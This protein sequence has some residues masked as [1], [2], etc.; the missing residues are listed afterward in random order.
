MK[1]LL[2]SFFSFLFIN[3]I[4]SAQISVLPRL[5]KDSVKIIQPTKLRSSPMLVAFFKTDDTYIKI[6]YGSPLKKDRK[7]FGDLVPYGKLWRTG[8]NEA[9]EIT[10]TKDI[11]ISGKSLKAGTYTIFTIPN[12]NSWT[13]LINND[14]GQWGDYQYKPEN[15]ILSFEIPVEKTP[16][17]IYEAFIIKFEDLDEGANMVMRWDDI[18]IAVPISIGSNASASSKSKKKNK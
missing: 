5:I 7:I 16:K 14:L 8:A 4:C 2:I 12:A 3:S 17:E 11:K 10:F 9:T 15:D 13:V 18:K 1:N 6:V